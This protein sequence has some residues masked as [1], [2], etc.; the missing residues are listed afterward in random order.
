MSDY[1]LGN[2]AE[3]VSV[4][5]RP[6]KGIYQNTPQNLLPAGAFTNIDGFLSSTEGLVRRSCFTQLEV[7]VPDISRWDFLGSYIDDQGTKITYG[8]GDG[9]FFFLSGSGFTEIPNFY[10]VQGDDVN[11]LV[12]VTQSDRVIQGN[13]STKWLTNSGIVPGDILELVNTGEQYTVAKVIAEDQISV[14]QVPQVPSGSEGDYTDAP[15]IVHRLLKPA[16]EW[17]IQVGRLD[18]YIYIVTGRN[19]V[20]VFDIDDYSRI[21]TYWEVAEKKS[22]PLN[23]TPE[24]RNFIPKTLEIHKDRVWLGNIKSDETNRLNSSRIT[25]TPILNPL[26]FRPERY[27]V[28]LI[29]TGGEISCLKVM[30]NLL[31]VYF[32]FGV[33]F[34]RDTSVPGDTLP[35]AFDEVEASNRG[36]LQPGAVASTM[37]GHYYVSTDNVYYLSQ[38][39]N[40]QA[41]GDPVAPLMFVPN[42]LNTAYKAINFTDIT[43]IMIGSGTQDG[44]YDNIWVYNY[45]TK[46]WTRFGITADTINLLA[47]GSSLTFQDYGEAQIF[48]A[49][50]EYPCNDDTWDT[51]RDPITKYFIGDIDIQN[52]DMSNGYEN[53]PIGTDV[54]LYAAK[55]EEIE[56]RTLTSKE[57]YTQ[58]EL[59]FQGSSADS[60]NN[61]I[62]ITNGNRVYMFDYQVTSDFNGSPVS[63]LLETGGFDF[64]MP[65]R[66]KTY[67]KISLRV[68]FAVL[69]ELR[70]RIQASN[71]SGVTWYDMGTLVIPAGGK[72]GRCNFLHT[73]SAARFRLTSDSLTTPYT[74]GEMTLDVRTRGRQFGDF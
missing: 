23:S 51:T 48:S 54:P 69:H 15:Y 19:T 25:W 72:E 52:D 14:E 34:G 3:R 8:L 36:V 60:L 12:T 30:G 27:Y 53:N 58:C 63:I 57:D 70:F 24:Q 35:L 33:Q 16:A 4:P 18:R 31:I 66:Y 65:E 38:D 28:D 59:P 64:N 17:E 21:L 39:L 67:Y 13:A 71:N 9:R 5:I 29:S 20:F 40:I 50:P 45:L 44:A 41:I 32:E 68:R 46:E 74:I 26:D 1:D 49:D 42:N 43:G 55:P 11:S 10:P 73:G 7:T 37:E 22:I 62:Y 56:S 2:Q 61:R 6:L 47:I